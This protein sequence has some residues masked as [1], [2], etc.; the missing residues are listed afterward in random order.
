MIHVRDH[1]RKTKLPILGSVAD[2]LDRSC[3]PPQTRIVPDRRSASAKRA[4]AD[5][6]IAKVTDVT[7]GA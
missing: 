3:L 1:D 7:A 2:P 4:R 5:A 6:R